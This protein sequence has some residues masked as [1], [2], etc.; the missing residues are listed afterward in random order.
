MKA[1][2]RKHLLISSIAMLLVA[3][4]ALGAATYAWFTSSTT[5]T[6]SGINVRTIQASELQI[7]KSDV[8][9]DTTLNY[10]VSNKILLP[11]STANGTAWFT[12][13]AVDRDNFAT[14]GTYTTIPNKDNYYFTEQLNVQNA[15]AATVEDVEIS[16]AAPPGCDYWRV[17]IVEANASG[18][19]ATLTGDFTQSVFDNSGTPYNAVT[20]TTAADTEITP[21]T[22]YTVSVGDLAENDVKYYNIYVWFEGQ[23]EECKDVNAGQQ[24]PDITF[25]VS[26]TT[27]DQT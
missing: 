16:F 27:A 25:T 4:V 21:K 5:A 2:S 15:G 8:V 10:G 18:I 13:N 23:D 3:A 17:A 9:W 11:T 20:S 12:G 24:I 6:A 22:T 26:G 1:K 14:D 7:S 19:E